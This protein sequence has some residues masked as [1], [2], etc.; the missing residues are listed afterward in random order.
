M[1]RCQHQKIT[2]VSQGDMSLLEPSYPTTTGHEYFN[3]AEEKKNNYIKTI[4]V[5]KEEI[6]KS[7]KEI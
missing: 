7:L 2:T 3:I 5:L 1:S 4:E 6:S